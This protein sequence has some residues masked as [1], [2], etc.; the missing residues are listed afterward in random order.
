[1]VE[2]TLP[3]RA[4]IV[5]EEVGAEL[6]VSRTVVREAFKVLETKGL[7]SAKPR[8]GTRVLGVD[9]WALLDADVIRWRVAGPD[10][11]I[12]LS[13]LWQTREAI[14]TFAV[15][16]CCQYG[17]A[18]D[19]AALDDAVRRMAAGPAGDL[20]TFTTADTD[21][22]TTVLRASGNPIFGQ[23]TAAL[24]AALRARSAHESQPPRIPKRNVELHADVARAIHA[25]DPNAAE[26]A[27]RLLIE[28]AQADVLGA[29]S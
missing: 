8:V 13:Q 22:H 7:V 3:E 19:L 20:K 21:F 25:R 1:V 16:A 11:R 14:E 5:P 23:F 17:T 24:A 29:G 6:G 15:R 28:T 27:I 10:G 18:D 4:Q 26:R 12:Q 9:H 2:G